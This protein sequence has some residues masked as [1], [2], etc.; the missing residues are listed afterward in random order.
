MPVGLSPKFPLSLSES[1]DFATNQTMKELVKQNFKNLL[2]TIPGERIMIP[3]FGVGIKRFLFEQKGA[4]ILENIIGSIQS[5]VRTYMPYIDLV[6]VSITD[7]SSSEE[8][9]YIKITYFIK[10][11]SEQDIIEISAI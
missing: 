8:I 10:P 2:L 6:D 4:G 3:D 9:V 7:D 1:G 11:L 5:Q